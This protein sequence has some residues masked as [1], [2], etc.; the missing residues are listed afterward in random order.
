MT[1]LDIGVI[2]VS[3]LFL[4]RGVWIGFVR[5]IAF[6]LA[7]FLG[8]VAA[9]TY[10]PSLS[11]HL[12]QVG[13]PQL[14]FVITYALLFFGTYV[15]IMVLGVGLKKVMH[16][17]F[18]GWFD[19]SMGAVFGLGKAIFIST[20]VFMAL[21]GIFSSNSVFIQKAFFSQYLTVSAKWMTSIIR[22]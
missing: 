2:A 22:D 11:Q 5:Q 13:N 6:L 18:L 14:R 10:Y 4:V 15:L 20:M 8:Y 12:S 3:V 1:A 19:R 7:L 16:I 17:T 9:G 21:T